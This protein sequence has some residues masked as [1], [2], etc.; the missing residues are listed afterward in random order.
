MNGTLK[1]TFCIRIIIIV[2]G[3]GIYEANSRVCR[4]AEFESRA[5]TRS[6]TISTSSVA[7]RRA[8][9]ANGEEGAAAPLRKR[10]GSV[11][12]CYFFYCTKIKLQNKMYKL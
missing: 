5:L 4:A 1:T 3:A 8:R 2:T 12:S 10:R 7:E 11:T 6:A 9:E